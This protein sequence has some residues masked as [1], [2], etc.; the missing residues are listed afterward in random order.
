[1]ESTENKGAYIS[2]PISTRRL[3]FGKGFFF[4][5]VLSKY[6][7]QSHNFTNLNFSDVTLPFSMVVFDI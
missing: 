1:M 4:H 5:L 6:A 2:P 7:I 3:I